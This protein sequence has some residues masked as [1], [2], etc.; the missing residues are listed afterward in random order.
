MAGSRG[1]SRYFSTA[2]PSP[3]PIPEESTLLE[4]SESPHGYEPT[5]KYEGRASVRPPSGVDDALDIAASVDTEP[6]QWV[7]PL[8]EDEVDLTQI[9]I[10]LRET[11]LESPPE[12]YYQRYSS[13]VPGHQ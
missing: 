10:D 12:T 4:V 1:K 7:D 2:L 9:T 6:V 3:P 13:R 5:G 8:D 11:M